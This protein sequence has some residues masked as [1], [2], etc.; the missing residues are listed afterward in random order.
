MNYLVVFSSE[1]LNSHDC[2]DQPEDETDE[3]HVEDAGDG[4]NQGIDDD[5]YK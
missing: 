1:H 4:L 5:L 2:E 3:Q